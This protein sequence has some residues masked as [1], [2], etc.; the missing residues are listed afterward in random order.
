M[1]TPARPERDAADPGLTFVRRALAPDAAAFY[2]EEASAAAAKHLPVPR[3]PPSS[4]G[5]A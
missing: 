2:L 5:L 3:Y 1:S 4:V